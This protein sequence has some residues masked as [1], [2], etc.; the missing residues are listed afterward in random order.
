MKLDLGKHGVAVPR[1][2]YIPAASVREDALRLPASLC[3]PLV[4]K[5]I[6][7][8]IHHKTRLGLLE[9]GVS[10]DAE[11]VEAIRQ[12]QET[13]NQAGLAIE[14]YLLEEM[15]PGTRDL[16]V[17]V[18]AQ[19]L[20]SVLM[21]GRGGVD[22][23]QASQRAFAVRPVDAAHIRVM[24]QRLG[25]DSDADLEGAETIIQQLTSYYDAN[26][27]DTLECNPVRLD[28]PGGPCVLDALAMAPPKSEEG[29]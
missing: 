16:I 6:G 1:H 24:L 3:A 19:P 7:R 22:V 20:G 28:A 12:M 18:S 29:A 14:G 10:T 5:G 9:V 23:E 27:L 25:V 2:T 11:L 13:A 4:V 8:L 15:I 21:L 26:G 17:S